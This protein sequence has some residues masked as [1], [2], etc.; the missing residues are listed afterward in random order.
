MIY[1]QQETRNAL[2]QY[3]KNNDSPKLHLGAGHNSLKGWFNTDL[4]PH[5]EK[6]IHYMDMLK[7]PYCISEN[8]FKYIYSE[9]NIEHFNL[10]DSHSILKECYRIL[11]PSGTI[12][13]ATPDLN[14]IIN[15]YLQDNDLHQQYCSWAINS[16]CSFA[17]ENNIYNKAVVLNNF[18]NNWGH[19]F[20]FDF[21]TIKDMLKNCGF[22][23][24]K[25]C[26]IYES[27]HFELQNLEKHGINIGKK[28]NE[29]ETMIIE[30]EK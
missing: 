8:S 19:K 10:E 22:K 2:N 25:Q 12:R 28:F 18:F 16:F 11:K 6:N 14:K 29:L 21:Q 9:H 7:I 13:I 3:Y 1:F 5:I 24:I 30:A 17:K 4:E 23:K 15:F 20:I 26:T 27:E